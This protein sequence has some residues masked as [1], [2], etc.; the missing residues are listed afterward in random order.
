MV[1]DERD[2][3][4]ALGI[5]RPGTSD[6]RGATKA[7]AGTRSCQEAATKLLT[8]DRSAARSS[9]SC[10]KSRPPAPS[11]QTG[12]T[13]PGKLEGPA[14]RSKSPLAT[15]HSSLTE[16]GRLTAC[17]PAFGG[18]SE[19]AR[20]GHRG[21]RGWSARMSCRTVHDDHRKAPGTQLPRGRAIAPTHPASSTVATSRIEIAVSKSI[22]RWAGHRARCSRQELLTQPGGAASGRQSAAGRPTAHRQMDAGLFRYIAARAVRPPQSES[23]LA[24]SVISRGSVHQAMVD[25][26]RGA[27]R[28]QDHIDARDDIGNQLVESGQARSSLAIA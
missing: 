24:P 2:A 3:A 18:V 26:G 13:G 22:H 21:A 8:D 15:N 11:Q 17:R 19:P 7:A 10:S 12:L 4:T 14:A 27:L 23:A 6:P 5:A 28:Q 9:P 16:S 20:V 1:H 25:D